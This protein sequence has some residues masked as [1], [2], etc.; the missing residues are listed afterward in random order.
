[1]VGLKTRWN[2][3]MTEFVLCLVTAQHKDYILGGS[4]KKSRV[5]LVMSE[6]VM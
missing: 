6:S 5:L 1:M 2:G 3:F 4:I